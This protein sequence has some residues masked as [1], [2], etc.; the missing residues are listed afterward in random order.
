M[1]YPDDSVI[2]SLTYGDIQA[3]AM[4]ELKR[5]LTAKDMDKF[6]SLFQKVIN[7]RVGEV[8]SSVL[9]DITAE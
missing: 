6:N 9:D 1:K 7:E 4:D 2:Y 5:K 3:Y 8:I